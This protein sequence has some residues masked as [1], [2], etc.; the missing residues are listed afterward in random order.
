MLLSLPLCKGVIDGDNGNNDHMTL[1]A[2]FMP[3]S[4]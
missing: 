2:I 4:K 1:E 3:I